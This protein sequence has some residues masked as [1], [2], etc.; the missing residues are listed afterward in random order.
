MNLGYNRT[1]AIPRYIDA[2]DAYQLMIVD[3]LSLAHAPSCGRRK[4]FAATLLPIRLTFPLIWS[5]QPPSRGARSTR[6]R[7]RHL[8]RPP[9]IRLSYT[10]G[11]WAARYCSQWPYWRQLVGLTTPLRNSA[12]P[13]RLWSRISPFGGGLFGVRTLR[14][15]RHTPHV[16]VY[17]THRQ[18]SRRTYDLVVQSRCVVHAY[19]KFKQVC[20]ITSTNY[21]W[22]NLTLT[23]NN[24]TNLS[25][26]R[27]R[28]RIM[29]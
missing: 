13:P 1:W 2:L 12:H 15:H 9:T 20:V 8:T 24:R 11:E 22:T 6:T 10:I 19:I 14:D 25:T 28:M 16:F 17:S 3:A 5:V 4:S 18:L 27:T 26:G 23:C 21:V 7:A 29:I